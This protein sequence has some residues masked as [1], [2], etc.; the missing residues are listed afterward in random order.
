MKAAIYF[1]E[2]FE[3]VEA[4]S[5]VDVL[6]R[7]GVEVVMVG[8]DAMTI[9]GAHHIQVG[10]DAVLSEVKHEQIDMMI[11][12]GGVL[13]VQNLSK[14]E[15][16]MAQLK[17][18]KAQNKWLAAICAAPSILGLAG[19]LEG[20]AATCY[21][22]YEDKLLGAKA[23][24]ERVVLSGKTITAIG[25]GASLDFGYKILEVLKGK[26]LSQEIKQ[27]MMA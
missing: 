11:L 27:K 8:L 7:G 3:E 21:P 6:R 18:F 2:G 9:T 17:A 12:P 26:E 16:L 13:G 1:A 25:A 19:L 5:V 22:G 4:L 24:G 14:S 23:T 10:M 15:S 20:E